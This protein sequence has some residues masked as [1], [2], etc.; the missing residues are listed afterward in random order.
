M[1]MVDLL[2]LANSKYPDGFLSEYYDEQGQLKDGS[3]DTLAKFIVSEIQDTYNQEAS[4]AEQVAEAARVL[5]T[6][7][8]EL[9]GVIEVLEGQRAGRPVPQ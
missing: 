5:E 4:D 1:K 9:R 8:R 6:A 3:G 7:R 2:N